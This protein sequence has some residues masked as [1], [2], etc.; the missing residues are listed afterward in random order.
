MDK[1]GEKVERGAA[2]E[3]NKRNEMHKKAEGKNKELEDAEMHF[4]LYCLCTPL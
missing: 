4:V 2:G 1:R 3:Q